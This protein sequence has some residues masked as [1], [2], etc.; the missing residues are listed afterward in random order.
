MSD[1]GSNGRP[2][3]DFWERSFELRKTGL[4]DFNGE[5][6][7][8]LLVKNLLTSAKRRSSFLS[9]VTSTFGRT[10]YSSSLE[11]DKDPAVLSIESVHPNVLG[12]DEL[13]ESVDELSLLQRCAKTKS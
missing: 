12:R 13:N 7:K 3:V 2:A 8:N 4:F 1:G 5:R 6:L 11:D 10:Q 9:I